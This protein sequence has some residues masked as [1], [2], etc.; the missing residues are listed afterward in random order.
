MIVIQI[1]SAKNVL[2]DKTKIIHVYFAPSYPTAFSFQK[3]KFYLLFRSADNQYSRTKAVMS[4][5]Y[6][7][8]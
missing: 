1:M 8:K 4:K 5:R 7:E 2:S 3:V 6:T